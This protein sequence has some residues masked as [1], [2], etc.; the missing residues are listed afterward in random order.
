M[1]YVHIHFEPHTP[2][3]ATTT[4]ACI[5]IKILFSFFLLISFA[6][7]IHRR[8]H[9]RLSEEQ[10]NICSIKVFLDHLRLRECLEDYRQI[11]F[12]RGCKYMRWSGFRELAKQKHVITKMPVKIHE[13]L[14]W[15]RI[16]GPLLIV[17]SRQQ[18]NRLNTQFATR[19]R[20][21]RNSTTEKETGL[22]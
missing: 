19:M 14:Y 5:S 22:V 2:H 15:S 6:L 8:R 11:L 10:G 21:L 1:S 12:C 17:V 3:T 4:V 18:I 9:R 16:F 13:I 7:A 20:K